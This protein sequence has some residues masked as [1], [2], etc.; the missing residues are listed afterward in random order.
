MIKAESLTYS[1]IVKALQRGDFYASQ[2]PLIEALWMEDGYMHV[3]C[4]EARRIIFNTAV[5]K[6]GVTDGTEGAPV[7]SASFKVESE[8]P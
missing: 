5:R 8:L 2:G 3:T 6:T 7:T 4:S 1:E